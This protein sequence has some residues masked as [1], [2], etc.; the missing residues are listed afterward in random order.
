VLL[1][2]AELRLLGAGAG[3]G[4]RDPLLLQGASGPADADEYPRP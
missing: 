4:G 3:A 1:G 2:G